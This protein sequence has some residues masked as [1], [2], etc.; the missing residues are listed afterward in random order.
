MKLYHGTTE[1]VARQALEKGV[2]PRAESGVSTVWPD[3]PSRSDMVYLS[4]AY[5][6]YFAACAAEPG[7]K[8]GI[9]EVETDLMEETLLHP[10]ED[11][12]EQATRGRGDLAPLGLDMHQRTGWFRTKLED[13]Q[14]HWEQSIEHLGNC[15]YAGA[16]APAEITRVV[17][18]DPTSNPFF[19]VMAVDPHITLMNYKFLGG[20]KYK[21]LTDWF[22]GVE[23]KL[24]DIDLSFSFLGMGDDVQLPT[25]IK[26]YAEKVREAIQNRAGIETLATEVI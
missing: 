25:G 10:D 3:C 11:F 19:S 12:L 13:F 2:L 4:R 22:F 1:V 18:Y 9:I 21:A 23:P 16:I 17:I 8:W 6:P 20:S 15:A 5:A 24:V 7:A 14:H 26:E